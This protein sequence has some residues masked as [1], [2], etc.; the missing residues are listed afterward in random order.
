MGCGRFKDYIFHKENRVDAILSWD[1][2]PRLDLGLFNV[3]I[4][5]GEAH[6]PEQ[7]IGTEDRSWNI[8]L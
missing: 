6:C 1:F 8:V 3:T 2:S 4:N 7:D 5:K